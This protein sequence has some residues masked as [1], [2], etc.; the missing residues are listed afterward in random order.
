MLVLVFLPVDEEMQKEVDE[1]MQKEVE[2][3]SIRT[4]LH[5]GCLA[6]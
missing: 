3:N 6:S 2:P 4:R 1:E 5:R